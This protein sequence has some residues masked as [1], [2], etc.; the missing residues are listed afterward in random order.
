PRSRA[1]TKQA[2]MIEMLSRP[3]GTTIAELA[4]TLG[5]AEHSV[6]GAIAAGLKKK[7]G[8]NVVSTK[9]TDGTRTYFIPSA[10]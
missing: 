6:R 1:D 10:A 8:L 5:W 2:K 4:G 7:L 3:G 9:T